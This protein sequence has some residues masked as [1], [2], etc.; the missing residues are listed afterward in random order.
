MSNFV[1]KSSQM[2]MLSVQALDSDRS[3]CMTAICYSSLISAVPA[4]EQLLEEKR[5]YAKF[6]I[7]ILKTK[8]LI[9]TDGRD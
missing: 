9:R 5:T 8:A 1:K 7:D 2:K 4:N 3:V 6:Q